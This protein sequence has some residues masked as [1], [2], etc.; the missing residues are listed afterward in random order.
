MWDQTVTSQ[1]ITVQ[2][3]TPAQFSWGARGVWY[4]STADCHRISPATVRPRV[5]H[6]RVTAK[7]RCD[8]RG[9]ACQRTNSRTRARC[10]IRWWCPNRYTKEVDCLV[11]RLPHHLIDNRLRK[12][13]SCKKKHEGYLTQGPHQSR[14]KVQPVCKTRSEAKPVMV[15]SPWGCRNKRWVPGFR[16][17][18]CCPVPRKSGRC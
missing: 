2:L 9:S 10:G 6:L 3:R 16:S 18:A 12:T 4:Q 15:S 14:R 13:N 7:K 11:L 17:V 8:G 5:W 1:R